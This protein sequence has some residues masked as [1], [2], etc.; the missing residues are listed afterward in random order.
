MMPLAMATAGKDVR[1]TAIHGGQR[2][3]KRLADLG[4]SPGTILHVVQAERQGPVIVAF[5]GGGRVGLG[6]GMAQK[7]Q[8]EPS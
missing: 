3:R 8:V 1:I 4:L 2:I 5:R 7:I 6:R